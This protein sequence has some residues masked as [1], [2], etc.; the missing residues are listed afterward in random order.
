MGVKIKKLNDV[1][2]YIA[3]LKGYCAVSILMMPVAF[4]NGGYFAS[5]ATL[6]ASGLITTVCVTK[7]IEC[8]LHF[9]CYSFPKIC[10]LALGPAGKRVID[11]MICMTQLSFAIS[12]LTFSVQTYKSTFDFF[13]EKDTNPWIYA[14]IMICIL[15]PLSWVR[16]IA[17]FSFTMMVGNFLILITVTIVMSAAIKVMVNQGGIAESI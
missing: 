7:L 6:I 8:G 15:T 17:K 1:E 5:P 12:Q 14:V 3:I 4:F 16:N 2:T 13:L 9:N 10:E 11:I